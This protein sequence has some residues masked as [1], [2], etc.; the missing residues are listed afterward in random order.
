MRELSFHRLTIRL[1][2][3]QSVDSTQNFAAETLKS[4]RE[5]DV[6]ISKIQTAGRGREGRPWVSNTGGLWMT[7]TLVPTESAVL[8][9]IPF[10]AA[11]SIMETLAYYHIHGS[12]V[13][14]PNDV[15][16]G[17]RKIAGILADSKLHG[18][19]SVVYLGVGINVNNDVAKSEIIAA[20]ATS[21]KREIGHEIDIVE[22]SVTFLKHLDANYNDMLGQ[23]DF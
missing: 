9:K 1:T 20:M 16:V 8:E 21:V 6:V 19:E 5:G 23:L 7:L 2:Y 10:I 3:L 15:Y 11:N 14:P 13:K 18:D 17:D 12:R 4:N 22:F